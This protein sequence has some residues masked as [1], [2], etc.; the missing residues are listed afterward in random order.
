MD[1]ALQIIGERM[2]VPNEVM[3]S[4]E[5]IAQLRQQ[6]QEQMQI[7]QQLEQASQVAEGAGRAAPMVKALGGADAFPVQ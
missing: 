4:Q 1:Q 2:A 5:E 7:Q 6:R 3:R